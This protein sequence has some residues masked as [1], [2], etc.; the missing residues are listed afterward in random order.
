MNGGDDDDDAAATWGRSN[1][2]VNVL[3]LT[4]KTGLQVEPPLPQTLFLFS[5]YFFT[6][7]VVGLIIG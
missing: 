2:G 3:I 4:G 7:I 1:E 5:S 6:E